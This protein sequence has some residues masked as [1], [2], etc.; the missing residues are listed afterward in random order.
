[1]DALSWQPIETTS[2]GRPLKWTPEL[3]PNDSCYYHHTSAE[4]PFG[5]FLLTWKGW[6]EDPIYGFDETPWNEV[7]YRGWATVKEAQEWAEQ[8][9]IRRAD[10]I[11]AA[12]PAP[13]PTEGVG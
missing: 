5:R 8:E 13:A 3:P 7:E 12:R 6:K 10:S 11:L 4:T 2:K 9:L 1:M